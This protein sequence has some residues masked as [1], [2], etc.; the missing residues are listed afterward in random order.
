MYETELLR[1]AL[2]KS[3]ECRE[4]DYLPEEDYVVSHPA[5]RIWNTGEGI[6]RAYKKR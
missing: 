1:Y 5:R 4:I 3:F 2:F 6:I